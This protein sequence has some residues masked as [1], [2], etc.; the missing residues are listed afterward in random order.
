MRV[1]HTRYLSICSNC[2]KPIPED[3]AIKIGVYASR[4]KYCSRLCAYLAQ[5]GWVDFDSAIKDLEKLVKESVDE[6]EIQAISYKCAL[7]F[8]EKVLK[9]NVCGIKDA[10]IIEGKDKHT[11]VLRKYIAA[12]PICSGAIP[13]NDFSVI[14]KQG[15]RVILQGE[16]KAIYDPTKANCP[17]FTDLFTVTLDPKPRRNR[18]RVKYLKFKSKDEI[19]RLGLA[20]NKTIRCEGCL[21]IVDG[22]EIVFDVRNVEFL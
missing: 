7:R 9:G 21:H 15:R 13:S 6:I 18:S 19:E 20:K 22:K 8:V 3:K 10:E 11:I 2:G 14:E 17:P 1:N 4:G 5:C 16:I 12:C